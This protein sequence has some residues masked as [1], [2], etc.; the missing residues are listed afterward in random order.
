[1][2]AKKLMLVALL[3]VARAVHIAASVLIAG[4][5][6]FEV[7]AFDF[8]RRPV[9]GDLHDVARSL[10][11]LVVWVLVAA[12]VSAVFWLWLEVVSMT[13]LSFAE[14]FSASM[15]KT[16][17]FETVF[18]HVWQFRLGVIGAALVLAIAAVA[19]NQ[20]TCRPVVLALWLLSVVLLVSLTWISH[21]AAAEIQPIGLIGDALHLCAVGGWI[22]GLVPLLIFLTQ[23][24]ISS[25]MAT[26]IPQ[27]LGRFSTLSLCC[28]S[29]LIASGISNSWLLVGSI[30]A[31]FTT[32]YGR[33]LVFK[34]ALFGVLLSF[35]ARNRLLVKAKLQ[36]VPAGSDVMLQLRRNVTLE[37]CLGAAVVVI[38]ACLGVTPPGRHP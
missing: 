34:L 33:L 17:F 19:R 32:V 15:W 18:G 22:G 7:V 12:L 11:R 25:G 5:S 29:V 2:A 27:V 9:S 36:K 16:V 37:A 21:A 20:A 24:R 4:S 10:V 6:T 14:S 8:I 1:L 28:V 23:T 13:G 38:V 26:I 35:G 31:L 30:H 3:I